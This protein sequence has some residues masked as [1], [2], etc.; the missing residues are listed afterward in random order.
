MEWEWSGRSLVAPFLLVARAVSVARG[1][2]Q[3][4]FP[5]PRIRRNIV[6]ERS[7]PYRRPLF[8]ALLLTYLH[9]LSLV[10]LAAALWLVI[11][12][13]D[14][15]SSRILIGTATAAGFTWLVAYLK[16]RGARCPLCKGT[17]FLNSGA[18]VSPKAVRLFP[19]SHGQTAVLSC[20]FT[21]RFRCMYCGTRF[22]LLKTP[23]SK[24]RQPQTCSEEDP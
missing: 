5:V 20:L 2:S 23:S 12:R 9:Y 16:R 17:P 15:L 24:Q 3:L 1:R 22:D 18:L 19:L 11:V 6:S 4:T 14:S 13:Q 8:A 7:V 10:A 21:H